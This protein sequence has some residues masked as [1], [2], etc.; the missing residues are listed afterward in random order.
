MGYYKLCYWDMEDPGQSV[1]C[2]EHVDEGACGKPCSTD[3]EGLGSY[4]LCPSEE[5]CGKEFIYPE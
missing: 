4:L 2:H 1:I 3:N 5:V